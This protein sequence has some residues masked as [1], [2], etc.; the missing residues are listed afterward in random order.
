MHTTARP[1]SSPPKGPSA[2]IESL[3]ATASQVAD[4]ATA[5]QDAADAERRAEVELLDRAIDV[6]RPALRALASRIVVERTVSGIGTD[7]ERSS[8]RVSEHRG[9]LVGG[10]AEP[11]LDAPRDSRGKYEGSGLYL[12]ADGTWLGV[13]YEGSWSKYQGEGRHWDGAEVALST[14]GVLAHWTDADVVIAALR[15][16]LEAQLNSKRAERTLRALGRA[17]KLRALSELL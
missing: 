8:Y 14:D 13:T 2:L 7:R 10:T 1:R 15:D 3:A 12:L 17:A 16:A 11:E 5:Q 9:L 4:L 6:V